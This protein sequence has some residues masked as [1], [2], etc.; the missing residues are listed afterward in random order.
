MQDA[1]NAASQVDC[2][3]LQVVFEEIVEAFE[4]HFGEKLPDDLRREARELFDETLG[5]RD[6]EDRWKFCAR[7]GTVGKDE[8]KGDGQPELPPEVDD[9]TKPGQYRFRKH[10]R[11]VTRCIANQADIEKSANKGVLTPALLRKAAIAMMQLSRDNACRPLKSPGKGKSCEPAGRAFDTGREPEFVSPDV[12]DAI[13]TK[14]LQ[15]SPAMR[16][17]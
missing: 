12:C 4:T 6:A 14:F 17:E 5:Q 9:T 1:T 2:D 16:Q 10:M 7:W 13:T 3:E 15:D 8:Q 11:H